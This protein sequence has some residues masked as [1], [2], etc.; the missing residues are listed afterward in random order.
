MWNDLK[1]E[2]DICTKCILERTRINPIVGEGNEKAQVLFVLDSVSEEE[3]IKQQLLAD[4]NG[5]Y[6]RIFKIGLEKV[7]FHYT[8]KMQFSREFD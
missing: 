5:K 2:I 1:L 8:Y 4:K 7:L 6:F 3:D